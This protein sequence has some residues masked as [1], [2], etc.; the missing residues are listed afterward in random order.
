MAE[1]CLCV[2]WWEGRDEAY[3]GPMSVVQGM[4]GSEGK[5]GT[6]VRCGRQGRGIVWEKRTE[7]GGGW[8]SGRGQGPRSDGWKQQTDVD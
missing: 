4:V 6:A 3:L 8:E 1:G 5:G 7:R 2:Q